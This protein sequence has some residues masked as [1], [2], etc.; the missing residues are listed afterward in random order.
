[1]TPDVVVDVGNSRIKWGRCGAGTVVEMVSLPHADPARWSRG[2]D[3]WGLGGVARWAVAGVHPSQLA[4]F[5]QWVE[6]RGDPVQVIDDYRQVPLRVDVDDPTSAGIDRLLTAAAAHRV[7][8]PE[9]A[10]VINVGTAVTADVV[11]AGGR[12]LGGVILPG[13]RL[14]AD[15][16]HAFTAKLPRVD[17]A[18]VPSTH[19]PGRNTQ[20][21]VTAG[22]RYAIIGAAY[23]LVDR[24]A[25]LVNGLPWVFLTGGGLGDLKDTVFGDDFSGTRTV[26]SLTLEGIRIAAEEL[27]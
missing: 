27:T 14:M 13:P 16:L 12:F 4:A 26:P 15:S 9:P 3:E 21:A 23:L 5:V 18:A 11:D 24:Y 20:D 1:M 8:R 2:L 7:A 25:A 17:V 19:P 10:I 22:I 6:G